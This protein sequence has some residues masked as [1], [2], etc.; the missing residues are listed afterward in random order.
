[1]LLPVGGC[2]SQVATLGSRFQLLLFALALAVKR[3]GASH[4]RVRP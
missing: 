1:M 4:R 2:E 3:I